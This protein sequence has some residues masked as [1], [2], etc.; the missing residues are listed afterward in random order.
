MSFLGPDTPQTRGSFP[1]FPSPHPEETSGDVP[2]PTTSA[3]L[4]STECAPDNLLPG[5]S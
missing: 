5:L 2:Q 1:T 4:T 3:S